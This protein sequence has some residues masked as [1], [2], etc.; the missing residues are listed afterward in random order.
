MKTKKLA[1]NALLAAMSA[2]LGALS[3]NLGNMKFTFE[4]LP[5]LISALLFGPQIGALAAG[6]GSALF[7]LQDPAWAPEFWITFI[8]KF[9][10]AFVA[11]WIMH[12]IS[13]GSDKVR[14][15]FA[16]LAGSLTY[17]LLYVTKNILSGHFI[18]GFTWQAAL[19]ETL[20]AKLPVTLANGVIAV[21]CAAI[22]AITLQPVLRKAHVLS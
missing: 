18:K 5:V 7:D 8:N 11:G 22:L 1:V 6:F 21:I 17:C 4:G 2:V 10:M 9:A 12:R 20:L 15:W 3:V 16:G 13:L 14:V 19:G